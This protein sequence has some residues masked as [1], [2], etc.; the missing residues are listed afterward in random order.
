MPHKRAY[1]GTM[2]F[3]SLYPLYIYIVA[4]DTTA[5]KCKSDDQWGVVMRLDI[6]L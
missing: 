4:C 2:Q 1:P 3:R 5:L 6:H